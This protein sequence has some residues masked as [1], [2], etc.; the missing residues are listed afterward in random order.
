MSMLKIVSSVCTF[1]CCACYELRLTALWDGEE[2]A[3]L[4]NHLGDYGFDG[5]FDDDFLPFTNDNI[6][7]DQRSYDGFSGLPANGQFTLRVDDWVEGD[8]GQVTNLDVEIEYFRIPR[9][10]P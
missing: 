1:H 8:S 6:N 2:R 7:F 10:D 3:V 4:W 9:E 5:G